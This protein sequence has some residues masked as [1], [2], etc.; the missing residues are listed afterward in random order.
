M[1]AGRVLLVR[2]PLRDVGADDDQRRP[3]LDLDRVLE[4]PLELV[5]LDVLLE[6]LHMP[7]V[8]LVALSSVLAQ[9]KGGVALDR[10]VVTVVE[11]DEAPEPEVAGE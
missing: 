3:V 10:D 5:E 1:G 9:R 11:S 6:V 7:A 8:C 4:R 2:C